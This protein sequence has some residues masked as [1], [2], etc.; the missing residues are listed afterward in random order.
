MT[1]CIVNLFICLMLQLSDTLNLIHVINVWHRTHSNLTLTKAFSCSC[2]LRQYDIIPRWCRRRMGMLTGFLRLG[3]L[4][5]GDPSSTLHQPLLYDVISEGMQ[6][7]RPPSLQ[8]KV[9]IL[10]CILAPSVSFQIICVPWTLF[11]CFPTG[12]CSWGCPY[13]CLLSPLM[14]WNSVTYVLQI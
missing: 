3:P 1:P 10:G 2:S 9:S 7:Y 14:W 12:W 8:V 5:S 6:V 4:S 13:V 11:S